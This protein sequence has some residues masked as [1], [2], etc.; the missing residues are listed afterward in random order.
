MYK[1]INRLIVNSKAAL[2]TS[3]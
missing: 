3:N 1:H 2:V